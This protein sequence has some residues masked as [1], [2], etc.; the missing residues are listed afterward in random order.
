MEKPRTKKKSSV[1][2]REIISS[3][4]HQK[5]GSSQLTLLKRKF[6]SDL[7]SE[8][9][10]CL[11]PM[12]ATL[13]T[14]PFN[15]H[16]WLFEIKWD[17][18][19]A[20]A[21]NNSGTVD[22]RSRGNQNYLKD[23]PPIATAVR[24]WGINLVVDGEIVVLDEQGK[25]DFNA[26]QGWKRYRDENVIFYY[27]FDLLWLDGYDLRNIPL[28]E[29]KEIL[30]QLVPGNSL[31]RYSDYIEQYGRELFDTVKTNGYEGIV[32]KRKQSMYWCGKRSKD[33]L[34]LPVAFTQR[35]VVAGWVESDVPG[36]PFKSL[37]FG[38]YDRGE[39]IYYH[40]SGSGWKDKEMPDL[41]K[42]LTG[43]EVSKNAFVNDVDY[44]GKKHWIKPI[45]A[46]F[47]ISKFTKEAEIR[48]PAVWQGWCLDIK[49]KG[50]TRDSIEWLTNK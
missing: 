4:I 5:T 18:Y 37:L 19:R 15:H 21:Y 6:N 50:I 47:K 42:A 2:E 13:S 36:K 39:L 31:I 35:F 33:W 17:G 9:P 7:K 1:K 12:L 40:H 24:D 11:S 32:A 10:S 48:H 41:L 46:E 43:M 28:I 30:S 16:D 20:I 27:V 14:E 22:L 23:Y 38:Y 25:P 26:L 3:N 29:R 49:P 45:V 34:K 8:F 44:E